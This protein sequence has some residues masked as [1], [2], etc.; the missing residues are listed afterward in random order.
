VLDAANC[1]VL[2]GWIDLQLNDIEWLSTGSHAPA[3]HARRVRDVL[4]YQA[5]LGVTGVVLATLAAP[6]DE[7]I[8]YLAGIRAVLDAPESAREAGLLGALVEGTFMNP[9]HHGA[10][11]PAWV[12][13]PSPKTLDRLLDTGAVRM[14]NIAPETAPAAIELIR[15][16]AARG[17]VV[18]CGH[19]RPHAERMR[20]A[21]LAG[22]RYAI[23]LGNGPTGSSLK[24]FRD[25]GM[26]EECLRNDAIVVTVILDGIH[27][28]PALVRDWIA[29]KELSRVIAVSD[30]AFAMG[31]PGE[32]F[33]VYGVSGAISS[34]G[35]YLR[36]AD[37]DRPKK[38]ESSD[39]GLT[40]D[41]PRLFGS[42]VTMRDVFENA[43]SLFTRDVEG[44]YHRRHPALAIDEAM[45]AA[46]TLTSR[47]PADLVGATDRGG[48]EPGERGDVV[49]VAV[50]EGHVRVVAT[51]L[52]GAGIRCR[53]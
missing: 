13:P 8:A 38:A 26:L 44:V 4:R 12:L 35:R 6:L 41:G 50:E 9:A 40:S 16:A 15:R 11:N 43:L 3:D 36:V 37:P 5:T 46:S 14:I 20:E 17:V 45:L 42:L 23:H 27:I 49:I 18:G 10:H 52:G 30:A 53:R 22:L 28:H 34:D 2:P 32:R 19:A 31:P 47:N 39:A 7:I 21:A 29:R 33:E 25:G 51:C 1:W 24:G 48:L